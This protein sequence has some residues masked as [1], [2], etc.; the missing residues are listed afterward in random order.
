MQRINE[1]GKMQISYMLMLHASNMALL[2]GLEPAQG[3]PN[4][5][6]IH[7]LNLSATTTKG[8]AIKFTFSDNSKFYHHG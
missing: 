7:R 6:Q 4:G 5:F 2:A 3:D 8:A 1:I